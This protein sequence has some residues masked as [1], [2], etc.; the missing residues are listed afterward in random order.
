MSLELLTLM[1]FI[2]CITA[3]SVVGIQLSDKQ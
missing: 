2:T 3:S 1:Y